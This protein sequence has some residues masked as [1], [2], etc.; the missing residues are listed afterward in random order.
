[1]ISRFLRNFAALLHHTRMSAPPAETCPGE[2]SLHL[3]AFDALP[4][5]IFVV[6][7]DLYIEDFNDAASRLPD[8]VLLA[9]IRTDPENERIGDLLHC[10][11]SSPGCGNSPA[12]QNCGLVRSVREAAAGKTCRSVTTIRVR[13]QGCFVP[14]EFLTTAA[15]VDAGREPLVLLVLED[16]ANWSPYRGA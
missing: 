7:A 9:A 12:C 1:V 16:K 10:I 2:I 14:I 3:A 4:F 11:D 6:T 15:P 5:P 8:E 13:K